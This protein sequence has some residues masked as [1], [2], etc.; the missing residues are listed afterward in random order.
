MTRDPVM[1]YF[2]QLDNR[3][4]ESVLF[5]LSSYK[6]LDGA[7]LASRVA[8]LDAP[9]QSHNFVRVFC[10]LEKLGLV[11]IAYQDST[12]PDL[13]TARIGLTLDGRAYL[14]K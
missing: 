8:I 11:G 6:Q 3:T 14:G 12:R 9:A 13:A 5:L 10:G 4:A 2:T 7:G 1:Q